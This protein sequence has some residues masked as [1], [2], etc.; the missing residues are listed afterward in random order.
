MR[1]AI[2]FLELTS[3][4]KGVE[5]ADFMIKA[6]EVDLIAAK[7]SCPGK[8]II[9]VNGD[10]AAVSAAVEAGLEAAGRFAVEHT[11]IPRVHPSVIKALSGMTEV[12]GLNALGI[13]EFFSITHS[14]YA[15][16]TAVKTAD[17]ELIEVRPG[18][19]IGGKSFVAFTG[20]VSAVTQSVEAASAQATADGMLV[21]KVVIPHPKSELFKELL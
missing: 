10:V 9:L 13:I 21:A 12:E 16:D 17:I 15:A 3:I 8:Y 2:G 7:P 11:V 19:G 5:A 4:A 18:I 6:A 1:D 14:I 20:D